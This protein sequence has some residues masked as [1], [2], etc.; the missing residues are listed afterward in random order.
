MK[1]GYDSHTAVTF[2]MIG[3]G[4]GT[5]L[6]LLFTPRSDNSDFLRARQVKQQRPAAV[7]A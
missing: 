2:L 4:V 3:V 7:S 5:L 6:T 1:S